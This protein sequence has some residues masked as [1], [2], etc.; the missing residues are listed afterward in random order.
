MSIHRVIVAGAG[1]VD[2]KEDTHRNFEIMR[3][4][5]CNDVERL[6]DRDRSVGLVCTDLKLPDGNWCDILRLVLGLRMSVEVRVIGRNGA[7]ALRFQVRRRRCSVL[8]LDA[9]RQEPAMA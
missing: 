2:T 5:S 3:A 9:A 4:D 1:V 6:L 8:A 7:P